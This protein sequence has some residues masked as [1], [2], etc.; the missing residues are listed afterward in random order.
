MTSLLGSFTQLMTPDTK[1]AQAEFGGHRQDIAAGGD[2]HDGGGQARGAGRLTEAFRLGD[3]AEE[4]RKRFTDEEWKSIR[5]A[6]IAAT[7][8]VISASP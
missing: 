5:L 7:F 1:G 8:Y 3:K 4:L 2:G 6:P